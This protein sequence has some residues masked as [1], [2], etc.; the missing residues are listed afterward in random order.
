MLIFIIETLIH[1]KILLVLET[2]KDPEF[3]LFLWCVFQNHK[4]LALLFLEQTK[5]IQ[6]Y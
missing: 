5:V 4:D 2:F 3:E 1:Y 6:V